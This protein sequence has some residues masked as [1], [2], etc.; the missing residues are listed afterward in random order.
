MDG[1]EFHEFDAGVV[2]VVEIE[3]P[4]TIAA[5]FG[6]LGRF[7]AGFD[8]LVGDGMNV[9]NAERDV[10][11]DAE[12]VLVGGRRDSE[13]VLDPVGAVGDLHGDPI[14]FVI[15]HAAVPV[16]PEAE[17]IFVEMIGGNAILHH[18][19]RM[20]DADQIGG[21]RGGRPALRSSECPN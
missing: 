6:R 16:R 20:N 9:W 1:S 19:A 8:E 18:E 4:L 21:V 10:I 5:D 3:L 2:G 13:H 14:G 7:D 11:H 12:S 17:E 15:F